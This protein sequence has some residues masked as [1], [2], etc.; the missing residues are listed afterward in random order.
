MKESVVFLSLPLVTSLKKVQQ[1]VEGRRG[2]VYLQCSIEGPYA[3]GAG[4]TWN[5]TLEPTSGVM[6]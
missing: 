5:Y 1:R 3:A 4:V 2:E 6:I